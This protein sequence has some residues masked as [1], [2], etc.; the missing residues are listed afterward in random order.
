MTFKI[1]RSW[2]TFKPHNLYINWNIAVGLVLR[3][4]N[5][6][7]TIEIESGI[8]LLPRLRGITTDDDF[9]EDVVDSEV[10]GAA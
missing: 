3:G 2:P 9:Q 6:E 7:K 1:P 8:N 4:L 10:P 5:Q